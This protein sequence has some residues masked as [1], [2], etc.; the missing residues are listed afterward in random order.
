MKFLITAGPTIEPIDDV[1]YISN[2]SSGKTGIAIANCV[3]NLG[4]EVRLI[5]GPT[6]IPCPKNLEVFS[7]RTAR[8]LTDTIEDNFSWADCLIMAAA[9]CDY[10]PK[11]KIS[12]KLKGKDEP[13]FLELIPNPD[14]LAHFGKIKEEKI[15]VGF[16]LET[17]NGIA[18]AIAKCK[19]KNCNIVALN[20][21]LS[22]DGENT[23]ITLV[24]PDG[25]VKPLPALAK[26]QA[27]RLLIEEILTLSGNQVA[28]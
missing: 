3:H 15:I 16:A 4:H 20:S 6:G 9:V 21:P 2:F 27:A 13:R 23:A 17:E 22:L 1:R 11:E 7:I 25:K 18:S 24:Y 5:T 28:D 8:E 10:R 14:I 12:G 26:S 19:S